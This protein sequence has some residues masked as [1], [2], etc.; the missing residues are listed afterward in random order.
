[1]ADL[2][3]DLCLSGLEDCVYGHS[4]PGPAQSTHGGNCPT[5]DNDFVPDN[6]A[7]MTPSLLHEAAT[8]PRVVLLADAP[9]SV[10]MGLHD[11]VHT[12]DAVL[13]SMP[14]ADF[15]STF[16]KNL[17]PTVILSPPRL[18]QTRSNKAAAR[19][20]SDEELIPKRSARLAAKSKHREQGRRRKHAR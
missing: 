2:A 17:E 11:D 20:P 14:V 9:A 5:D 10:Y 4:S 12:R 1:M 13:A 15:I 19:E 8:V 6:T 3:I 16:K 7:A 18:R